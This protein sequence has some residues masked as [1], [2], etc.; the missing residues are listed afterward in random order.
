MFSLEGKR[1][2]VVKDKR[3]E[4]ENMMSLFK[5]H[6]RQKTCTGQCTAGSVKCNSSYRFLSCVIPIMIHPNIHGS[7]T[8]CGVDSRNELICKM[9]IRPKTTK[10]NAFQMETSL[11]S[12]KWI[13][14]NGSDFKHFP[15]GTQRQKP[16]KASSNQS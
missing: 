5:R 4:E 13:R 16:F 14:K 1:I 12:P 7:L 11:N 10:Q 6:K 2:N 15:V 8:S 9:G 3:K